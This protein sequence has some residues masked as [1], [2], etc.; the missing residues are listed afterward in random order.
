MSDRPSPP[1]DDV[2]DD[3]DNLMIL[4][5]EQYEVLLKAREELGHD[6]SR[7]QVEALL[8]ELEERS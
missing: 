6:L 2:P 4:S 7:G 5:P 1:G 8:K 3:V